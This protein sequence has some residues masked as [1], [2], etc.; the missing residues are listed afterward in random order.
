[1]S[2]A[3]AIAT[4]RPAGSPSRSR[5]HLASPSTAPLDRLQL[6][7]MRRLDGLLAGDHAGLLPGHGTERGEA[8]PYVPGDDPRHI[9]WAVTART[10]D[11]HVRD[12]IADHEL[13]LWLV[14]DTSSSHA[15][16]HR[17]LHQARARRGPRP[18]R[19]RCSPAA[20]ATASARSPPARARRI[21]PGPL[22]PRPHRR[23]ARRP[24]HASP[25]TATR[26]DLARRARTAAPHRPA[27]RAWSSWSP[28]SSASRRGSA[29]CARS[30][31][32]TR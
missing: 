18:A 12:T 28:T 26:G 20:A 4:V 8:G 25:S 27:P 19:S 17:P 9:D 16:R 24:A 10:G 5:A 2:V 15:L 31:R 21:D 3:S 6:T 23:A 14:L 29:R 32:A 13:E 30:P 22:G 7:V 11:P 1:M